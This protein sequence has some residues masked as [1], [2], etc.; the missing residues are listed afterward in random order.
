MEDVPKAYLMF[1]RRPW[2]EQ[3]KAYHDWGNSTLTIIADT[4]TVTLSTKK[5]IMVHPFQRPCNL[6]DTYD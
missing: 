2:L 6:D 4:N 3:A 5:R 1:L